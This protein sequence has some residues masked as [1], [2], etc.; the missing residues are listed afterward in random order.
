LR[1]GFGVIMDKFKTRL[2][3][4]VIDQAHELQNHV[5]MIK[6]SSTEVGGAR[7]HLPTLLS[8]EQRREWRVILWRWEIN[9]RAEVAQYLD[10]MDRLEEARAQFLAVE[11][12]MPQFIKDLD[13]LEGKRRPAR[14][15]DCNVSA[16]RGAA[17]VSSAYMLFA[18]MHPFITM[19]PEH[20]RHVMM[21][22]HERAYQL[23]DKLRHKEPVPLSFDDAV[24]EETAWKS[25]L[26]ETLVRTPASENPILFLLQAEILYVHAQGDTARHIN[27]ARLKSGIRLLL[28]DP[29]EESIKPQYV[30]FFRSTCQVLCAIDKRSAHETMHRLAHASANTAATDVVRQVLSTL[31]TETRE[32]LETWFRAND[33]SHEERLKQRAASLRR[34]C[35]EGLC[36]MR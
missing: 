29:S 25:W 26:K 31:A 16:L 5:A 36:R 30:D 1:K 3:D 12:L 24:P 21:T 18:H 7:I 33:A 32:V 17:S 19:S 11:Q 10:T 8:C 9:S 14:Y 35:I 6:L 20:A 15:P 34:W 22:F 27:I 23:W 2:F 28:P 13:K 4:D